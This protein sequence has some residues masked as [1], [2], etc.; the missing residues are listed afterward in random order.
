L[1]NSMVLNFGIDV[2]EPVSNDSNGFYKEFRRND[3]A[4]GSL[5]YVF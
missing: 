4:Y 5:S 1:E 2:V 3:F